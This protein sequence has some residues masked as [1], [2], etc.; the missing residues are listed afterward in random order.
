MSSNALQPEKPD[1]DGVECPVTEGSERIRESYEQYLRDESRMS[2]EVPQRI[3]FPR[4]T[5]EAAA[6]IRLIAGRGERVTLSAS[7]TGIAG[8]AV[9][10]GAENI[11]S[12]ENIVF[13]PRVGCD[14]GTGT[15]SITVGAGTTLDDLARALKKKDYE[16][17]G[18]TPSNLFYPVDPT[19]R[20][21]SLGGTVAAN[22]SGART[23]FYG[24]TRDWVLGLVV[25]L[26]DGR[27]L[28]LKRGSVRA[29]GDRFL[30]RGEDGA[31]VS[32]EIPRIRMPETKHVAG[33][34][35]KPDMDGVDLFIGGE[36]TLGV[37]TEIELKLA[38][39]PAECLYLCVFMPTGDGIVDLVGDIKR[40]SIPDPFA[41]E[42]MDKRSIDIL[43]AYRRELAEASGVLA[44]PDS[45]G[46]VLYLEVGFAGDEEFERIYAELE[47]LMGRYGIP[48]DSTWAGFSPRDMEDMKKFRHALP[49]RIN[50]TIAQRKVGLPELVK[51]GTDMAVPDDALAEIMKAYYDILEAEGL[52]FAVFGHIGNGHLHV[53]ILPR[54]L[55]ELHLAKRLYSQLARKV[56]TLGGSVAAEHGI[57]RLK[58]DFMPIQYTEDEIRGMVRLR[59]LLD[60]R[61][62]L[63][64]GVIFDVEP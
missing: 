26:A 11:L 12:L 63:N 13:K 5:L 47:R 61:H 35:L 43:L 36:G 28:R 55:K 51:V 31:T 39:L 50:N 60:P 29:D 37:I 14:E 57:G 49:E 6:A 4:T 23:L 18:K 7:R 64:P 48:V 20:S 8:G 1:L 25:V 40:S 19:E 3:Y 34:Y 22:A 2:G 62:T 30:L 10:I 46:A 42:Y 54:T 45:V 41:I 15:W 52:E 59:D 9:N 38:R 21:A 17:A 44:I 32:I 33:Y 58:K 53:N 24:P 56:V 27:V 16:A